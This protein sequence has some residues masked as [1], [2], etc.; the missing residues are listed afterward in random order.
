MIMKR[1]IVCMCIFAMGLV[2]ANAQSKN[3]DTLTLFR[4]KINQ[5]DKEIVH[6][7]GERMKAARTIGAYKIAH[8]MEVVQSGRFN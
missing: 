8:K 3:T 7:L 5:L 1:R 4:D 6:L 2:T